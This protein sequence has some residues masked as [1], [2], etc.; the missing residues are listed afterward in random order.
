[1][2]H[3]LLLQAL[4]DVEEVAENIPSAPSLFGIKIIDT[5][6]FF[7]LL[8]RLSFTLLVTWI[9][10]YLI[11]FRRNR[12]REYLFTFFTFSVI[13]FLMS[14]LMSNVK[15]SIG[16]AF[17]LF[18]VFSILRYRTEVLPIKEMTYLFISIS[19]AV[20][21][22]ISSKKISYAEILLTNVAILGVTYFMELMLSNNHEEV[23]PVTYEK[24]DLIKPENRHQLIEDLRQRTGLPVHRVEIEKY[25]LLR[26]SVNLKMYF[27]HSQNFDEPQS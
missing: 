10:V 25:D 15:L 3:H 14:F 13:I 17:G 23:R 11:Y 1:M 19:I 22:A 16:F 7:H 27:I 4:P 24:I 9:L 2:L 6:D 5:Q 20:I 26:D 8:V 12:N 21:N 18:A